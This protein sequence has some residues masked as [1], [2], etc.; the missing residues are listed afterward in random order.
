MLH[1]N[2]AVFKST[3]KLKST[4]YT[5]SLEAFALTEF[6]EFFWGAE[7]RIRMSAQ[8]TFIELCTLLRLGLLK[9]FHCVSVLECTPLQTLPEIISKGL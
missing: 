7:S 9:C 3:I 5:I 8:E 2:Q 1:F 4:I 6:N